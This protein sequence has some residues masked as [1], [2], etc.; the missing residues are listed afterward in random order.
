[1]QAQMHIAKAHKSTSGTDFP[2]VCL[3]ANF[4]ELEARFDSRHGNTVH[5]LSERYSEPD[6]WVT[7]Q[8]QAEHVRL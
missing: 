7:G 3:M 6:K 2:E 1:M 5:Y 4:D 8:Q